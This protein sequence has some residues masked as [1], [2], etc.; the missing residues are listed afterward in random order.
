MAQNFFSQKAGCQASLCCILRTVGLH[1]PELSKEIQETTMN[2]KLCFTILLLN[3]VG[4]SSAQESGSTYRPKGGLVAAKSTSD[5]ASRLLTRLIADVLVNASDSVRGSNNVHDQVD[6]VLLEAAR[7]LN[8]LGRLVTKLGAAV[9]VGGRRLHAAYDTLSI[10]FGP[11]KFKRQKASLW[12]LDIA[13]LGN[14]TSEARL[15]QIVAKVINAYA[16]RSKPSSLYAGIEEIGDVVGSVG[17]TLEDVA[18]KLAAGVD[19]AAQEVLPDT[20][21]TESGE[22]LLESVSGVILKHKTH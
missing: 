11:A 10:V 9:K 1:H 12:A 15:S 7:R 19:D 2:I 4:L 14:D 20:E 16:A 17:D 3:L 22:A 13:R 6:A 5:V 18:K 21:L 8:G